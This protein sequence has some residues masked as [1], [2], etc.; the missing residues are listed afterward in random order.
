MEINELIAIKE[1]F[2]RHNEIVDDNSR[3]RNI[4]YARSAFSAAF[5][6]VAGPSLLGKVLG[7]NHASVVHYAK[8]HDS[9]INYKDYKVLYERA[10]ELRESLFKQEDLP[11][12]N[13][14]DLIQII[15]NLRQELREEREK[16]QHLYIYKE[17]FFKL[18]ELI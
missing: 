10:I 1:I 7:R 2:F 16:N 13:H 9:L 14:S 5:R 6:C 12:M 3:K 17:K 15:K 8:S 4:V 18:K 11:T